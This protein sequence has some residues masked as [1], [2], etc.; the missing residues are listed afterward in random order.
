MTVEE[1]AKKAFDVFM[2]VHYMN[3]SDEMVMTAIIQALRD[4]IED[5]AKIADAETAT[6]NTQWR[7]AA[8]TITDN[9]RALAEPTEERKETER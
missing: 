6:D 9:I 4:Q 5:C 1:R 8:E 3:L 7:L 2:N